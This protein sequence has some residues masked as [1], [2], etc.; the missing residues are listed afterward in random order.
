MVADV[1]SVRF[2]LHALFEP[3]AYHRRPFLRS[4]GGETNEATSPLPCRDRAA[5][6]GPGGPRAG[7]Q[8]RRREAQEAPGAR[9]ARAGGGAREGG[10]LARGAAEGGRGSAV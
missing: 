1:T 10:L 6:G 9:G 8:A 3:F 4:K 5:G 2:F 7:R